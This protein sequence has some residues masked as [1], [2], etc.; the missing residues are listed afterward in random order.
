MWKTY[1]YNHADAV[2]FPFP[3]AGAIRRRGRARHRWIGLAV[4]SLTALGCGELK[5]I[6]QDAGG[7]VDAAPPTSSDAG[8]PLDALDPQNADLAALEVSASSRD[9]F[10]FD[11][12]VTAY[13]L[14]FSPLVQQLGVTASAVNPAATVTIRG[15]A[16][17]AGE[18]VYVP[19]A[20]SGKTEIGVEVSAVAGNRRSYTI[21][22][23]RAGSVV[24]YVYGKA[25]NPGGGSANP[26]RA[27]EQPDRFTF[28]LDISGD[29]LVIGA[30]FEDSDG[31]GVDGEQD[32]DG[33]LLS[34]AAYVYRRVAG[35]WRQEAYL[36]A[37]NTGLNDGFGKAVAIDGARIA[38]GAD[39]EDTGPEASGAVYIF[40]REGTTWTQTAL[41]K[42]RSPQQRA[43]FGAG[44]DL[45]GTTL[46]VGAPGLS[47]DPLSFS[48]G[49]AYVF[50]E[51]GDGVWEEKAELLA[52]N[53]DPDDSFG[54][55][56][57]LD[58]A[59]VAIGAPG[60]SSSV[61]G[62]ERDPDDNEAL[63]AGAAY[64]FH[65]QGGVWSQEAY[66]KAEVPGG[67]T[68]DEE[69]APL[70]SVGDGFGQ[71]LALDGDRLLVGA[72]TEDSA[73]RELDGDQA[74]NDAL[75]A[76]A[77]YLFARR[78][79]D[80]SWSQEAYFKSSAHDADDFF[81]SGIGL[82][83]EL[84]AVGAQVEDGGAIGLGGDPTDNGA[85]N[86]GAVYLFRLVEG[87]WREIEYIKPTNT[88]SGD[89]FGF[90][91]VLSPEALLISSILEDGGIPG[92]NVDGLNDSEPNS[93]AFYI[94]Q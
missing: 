8:P 63:D 78:P 57:S 37:S 54:F 91:L 77:A 29:T 79:A 67:P 46:V 50:E 16:A 19:L 3:H 93:G 92:V 49:R 18:T 90:R 25:S 60:E 64:I 76:G 41:L 20:A 73:S 2:T 58:G 34:G 86:S 24:Q 80:G 10:S 9:L 61:G 51:T 71:T 59:R 75:N 35:E 23:D 83:G 48:Q 87:E 40:E 89:N 27:E 39:K 4:C 43:L 88:G 17:S 22:A 65:R 62:A 1:T 28:S 42:P 74:N 68:L 72:P 55:A 53:G 14:S 33:A 31:I 81:G 36:K 32:N 12:N 21:T 47:G 69:G 13:A 44:L 15:V 52:D 94:F 38:I 11:A 85:P 70:E 82:S 26:T 56:I 45:Q 66:L 5:Q 7:G 6:N 84:L 30:P